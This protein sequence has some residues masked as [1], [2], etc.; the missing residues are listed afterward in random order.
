M[1][2][3]GPDSR[4]FLVPRS[5]YDGQCATVRHRYPSVFTSVR[6]GC[7][8]NDGR[9]GDM[10]ATGLPGGAADFAMMG[11]S[12]C[13]TP[14]DRLAYL[15]EAKR[16][17]RPLGKLIIVEPAVTFGGP[18]SWREG[19]APFGSVITALAMR[20]ADANDYRI[21]TGTT[22]VALVVDNNSRPAS[23]TLGPEACTWVNRLE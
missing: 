16:I 10:A 18:Q 2:W 7:G 20:L 11:L 15:R 12:M 5:G 3:A 19:V 13:G 14:T 6:F 9:I 17:L 23:T 22:L 1:P 21:E 8:V 4:S